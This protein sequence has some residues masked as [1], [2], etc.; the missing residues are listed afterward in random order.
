MWNLGKG[1]SEV[2]SYALEKLDFI[3]GVDDLAARKSCAALQ[4][5]HV[6]TAGILILAKRFNLIASLASAFEEIQ[7]AGLYIHDNLI[8]QLLQEP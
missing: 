4:I 2:P 8:A 3:A 5:R 6:G 1:E 7:K